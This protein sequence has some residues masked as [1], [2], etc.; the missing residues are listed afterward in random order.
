MPALVLQSKLFGEMF[1]SDAMRALFQDEALVGRYLDVE[2]AL[3]RAQAALGIVP[4]D[5]AQAITA[6]ASVD[7]IDWD[8]LQARTQ[9]VGYPI[10][11][12]V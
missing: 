3:A 1:G 4:A 10:L 9:I 7:H 8:R 5:A 12:L 2:T 11:P 6:A